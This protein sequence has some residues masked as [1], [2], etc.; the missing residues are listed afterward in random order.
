MK[1][2]LAAL[3]LM[4][5]VSVP[6]VA[7]DYI[8]IVVDTSGSMGEY[9]RSARQTRM[10]VAKTALTDVLSNIPT[11][12]KVGI[13]SFDGWVYNRE[14]R[15]TDKAKMIEAVNSM[16]PGGGTPLYEYMRAGGTEILK[17]REQAGNTGTYKLLVVT[18]GEASDEGLNRDASFRDG[19]P[20]PGVLKDIVSRG[21][22]VD[23]IGLDM[24][25]DH[26]LKTQINGYYMRGDD[27]A[28]LKKNIQKSIH[29]EVN[30]DDGTSD[31]MFKV[32]S[33]LPDTFAGSV[34]TALTTFQNHP[35]GEK[36]P[37]KVV[38]EDGTISLQQDPNNEPV[39]E[40][41][42]GGGVPSIVWIALIFVAVLLVLAWFIL[43]GG[44]VL[45]Y[46]YWWAPKQ[47]QV[48]QQ[49]EEKKHQELIASTSST[50][51]YDWEMNCAADG[52]S[53]YAVVRS[54]NMSDLLINDY[55]GKLNIYDDGA[56][57]PARLE[58]LKSG[59]LDV[60]VFTWDA[61]I[62]ASAQMG[63]M[64]AVI[65]SLIDE[66]KGADAI[67]ANKKTFPSVDAMNDPDVK[68]VC[69][70]DSPSETLVR[71]LMA[72]FNLDKLASN[73]FEFKGSPDEVYAAYQK[74]KPGE[75]KV[76]V[77]WE[78]YVSKM[79]QNP[80]YH[81]IVGSDKVKG[82]IVDVVVARREYLSQHEDRVEAFVKCYLSSVFKYRDKSDMI[83][84]V[85]NDAKQTGA[86]LREEQAEQ[87][88]DGVWWKNT[89]EQ[90]G[91]FGLVSGS[92]LQHMDE[93]GTN[94]TS[95]LTKTGAISSDPTKG[96]PN[97]LYYDGIVRRLFDTSWHPG[98]GTESVRKESSLRT[99]SESEWQ[100]LRA[101][102]TL[103]VPRLVFARGTSRLN[104]SSKE[105][106]KLLAEKLNTWPQYYLMVK[107]NSVKS[108]DPEINAAN[109]AL[110]KSRADAAVEWL[111]SNGIDRNRI[112]AVAERF[113]MEENQDLKTKIALDVLVTPYTVIP[114]AVG[115]SLLLLSM[116]LGGYVGFIGFCSMLFSVG[117]LIWNVLFNFDHIRKKAA[118]DW[119]NQLKNRQ[120]ERLDAL[121][122]K[123]VKN[124]DPRDQTALRDLRTLYDEFQKDIE[125]GKISR[126]VTAEMLSQVEQIFETCIQE[127]DQSYNIWRT[128]NNKISASL[129][130][131]LQSQREEIISAVQESVAN[132][133]LVINEIRS[134]RQQSDASELRALGQKLASHLETAKRVEERVS[135]FGTEE[136][137]DRFDKYVSQEQEW[138][139]AWIYKLT[140]FFG[141]AADEMQADKHVMGATYDRSIEAMQKRFQ[142]VKGAVAELM[143]IE[144]D[145][146]TKINEATKRVEHLEDVK[147]GARGMLQQLIER[148]RADNPEITEEQIKRHPE[149]IEHSTAYNDADSTQQEV[150]SRIEELEAEVQERKAQVSQYTAE[151][152][153]MQREFTRLKE[154]KHEAIAD[155]QIAQQAEAVDNVLAGISRDTTDKDLEAARAARKKARNKAK[156]S[157]KM[158]GT[159]AK[160][161]ESQYLQ[162]ASASKSNS[163]LDSLLDF[164]E[165][166]ESDSKDSAMIPE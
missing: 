163:K 152:Q 60:A 68:F 14:F 126:S 27:P 124:R 28:S 89:Q 133:A 69:V 101:V 159:D 162:F 70:N 91:H 121:D 134:V 110:A 73:P 50:A 145:K 107:G 83:E 123:L 38:N 52:F 149:Y 100:S 32:V 127:L 146:T 130:E 113:E 33:E 12:T 108:D 64:P 24:R 57:Y 39:P 88:V 9:M 81:A 63:D 53:G 41:G 160:S 15:T 132:M 139:R 8:L 62:K 5:A 135:K 82:Y 106:L 65:V 142:T 122:R 76:F 118:K 40:V 10:Q 51:R 114:G 59:E 18:D 131:Q 6:A 7:D 105:T 71:V 13:L 79:V 35:I 96:R 112:H 156:I 67:I 120:K 47:E 104:T 138:L 164:G 137:L 42:E 154:E 161:Q 78:P 148:L 103:S 111:V 90:Y 37:I 58:R 128:M 97:L 151:L 17:I 155:V 165:Q 109:M 98:F 94:I 102:G 43:L 56:D 11:S 150:E 93:I 95:V 4:L 22:I 140:G 31:E 119:S 115:A 153:Q 117:A 143:G 74:C 19:T 92:G 86:P 116:I 80:D 147:A 49:E 55:K 1:R 48:A 125:G 87:L 75:K 166:K 157:S 84:L 54:R 136:S 141:D 66:T 61:L 23:A 34:I 26:S 25:G 30:F 45:A 36:P 3:A 21:V 72:Y 144:E 46:K 85:L 2:F 20:K 99:L 44:A 129:K 16:E 158:A 29:A 77:T